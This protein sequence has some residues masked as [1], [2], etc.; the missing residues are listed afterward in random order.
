MTQTNASG[1]SKPHQRLFSSVVLAALDDA[2]ADENRHGNG[3]VNIA[4]W[5]Q[6][7]DGQ[8]VL[9]CAGIEPN[10]RCVEGLKNFVQN[11][12][13][14]SAALSRGPFETKVA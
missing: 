5:A 1:T 6:S 12:I 11:G 7:R 8:I 10:Q 3:I 4:R 13:K 9:T 14:T 2:I